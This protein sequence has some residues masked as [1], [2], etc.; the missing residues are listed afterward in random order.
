MFEAMDNMGIP[1]KLSRLT[2]MTM[3]QTK[4][5]VKTDNQLSTPFKFNK[6]V[7]QGDGLPTTLF[8]LALHNAIQ[9]IDQRGTIYTKSSQI[10]A[11]ADDVVIITRSEARMKQVH[12][13]VEEKT[14]K[15]G[16]RVN[17]KKTKYMIIS[18]AQKRRQIPN[19]KVGDKEFET[20]SSFKYLGNVID[21]EGR[22]SKCVKDRTQAV[23]RAYA[24]NYCMLKSKTIR[25]AVKIQI[26]S[27]LTRQ[28]ATYGAE[29][30]THI[31]F[32]ENSLRIFERKIM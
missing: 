21:K 7:K 28:V 9:E 26:C 18:I 19:L 10:C 6:G 22:I 17:E 4:A 16:L 24:A 15:M 1:Q 12:R 23:N 25:R 29:T 3:C 27:T 2:R 11:Y 31:K 30:W 14:Q 32:D 20:V 13:E 5:R 8:I